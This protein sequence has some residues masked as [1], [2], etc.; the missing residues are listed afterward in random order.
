MPLVY[1]SRSSRIREIPL[2]MLTAG[3]AYRFAPPVL[4]GTT[5][6]QHDK[7]PSGLGGRNLLRRHARIITSRVFDLQ[8]SD[9][10]HDRHGVC[11]VARRW[12]PHCEGKPNV[13]GVVSAFR[14]RH[15]SRPT[16][17]RPFW[18][19]DLWA[20][21]VEYSSDGDQALN[22]LDDRSPPHP[23]SYSPTSRTPRPDPL[24]VH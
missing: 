11:A 2:P 8:G 18:V 1:C 7:R 4:A 10:S 20:E 6:S 13:W 17:C 21:I 5:P 19:F 16:P 15:V 3:C 14:A 23:V 22:Q 12:F 9:Q 24:D